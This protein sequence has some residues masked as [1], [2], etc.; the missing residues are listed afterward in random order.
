MAVTRSMTR[1]A[2]SKKRCGK[3]KK[4]RRKTNRCVKEKKQTLVC[5]R[6]KTKAN[7]KYTTC[8]N[9]RTKRQLR[10]KGGYRVVF[11]LEYFGATKHHNYKEKNHRDAKPIN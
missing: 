3:G 5:F 4:L 10:K 8:F 6:K 7:K 11:P 9:K 2:G 1:N